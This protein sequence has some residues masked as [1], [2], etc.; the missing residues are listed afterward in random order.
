MPAEPSEALRKDRRDCHKQVES[1]AD[2]GE[3]RHAADPI[4]IPSSHPRPRE[5]PAPVEDSPTEVRLGSVHEMACRL[6]MGQRGVSAGTTST[7][8]IAT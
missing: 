6:I 8:K 5:A 1:E 3:P 7:A 2:D 4:P